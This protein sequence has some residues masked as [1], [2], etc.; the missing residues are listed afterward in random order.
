MQH[1]RPVLHI[2]LAGQLYMLRSART[3]CLDGEQPIVKS[4]CRLEPLCHANSAGL[5]Y[6]CCRLWK[7]HALGRPPLCVLPRA[8]L[9]SDLLLAADGPAELAAAAGQPHAR[10]LVLK[11][12]LQRQATA[13]V[14]FRK[15]RN[16]HSICM[17][18]ARQGAPSNLFNLP[19]VS[20]SGATPSLSAMLQPL[21][22]SSS[23]IT[24]TEWWS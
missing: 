18:C 20:N 21:R 13:S 4:I 8:G 14:H 15:S 23:G 9:R 22:Q 3:N 7:V 24:C 16:T 5:L 2:M 17:N 19:L 6:S 11:L 12:H 1:P 10:V